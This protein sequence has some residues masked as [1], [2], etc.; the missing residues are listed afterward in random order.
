MS[1]EIRLLGRPA[2]L[3]AGGEIQP[4]R[5]LQAW[6]LLARII[7]ARTAPDRRELAQELFPDAADPLGA[8]RW[9]LASLRRALKSAE[10]LSGDPIVANLPAGTRVDIHALEKGTIDIDAA[11]DL[12]D[13][14]EPRSS[15]SFATWLL[16]ERERI[17]ALINEKLRQEAMQAVSVGDHARAIHLAERGVRRAPLDEGA[18]ILLVKSLAL[19]G[20]DAAAQEH[21]DATEKAF[22]AELGEKPTAALRSAARRTVFSDAGG[23][24][25]RAVVTSLID[26]GAAALAAGAVDAGLDSLRRAVAEAERAQDRA[27]QAKALLELGTALVHSVRGF[28]DEGA[29]LLRQSVQLAQECGAAEIAIGALR[30]AGYVEA[31]AGRR[32]SAAAFLESALK[33]GGDDDGRAGIHSVIGFNLVDWGRTADG[34][35]HLERSVEFARRAQNRRRAA[36]ALSMG[37]MG[38]LAAGNL[39]AAHRWLTECRAIVEDLRWVAFRPWPMASLCE[40]ELQRGT[41][42]AELRPELESAFALS[43]QLRDPCWEGAVARVMALTYA[44]TND[45][46]RAMS[47]LSEARERCLRETDVYAA[48]LVGIVAAQAEISLQSGQRESA[49]AIARELLSLAAKAHMDA[50]V[51]RAVVLIGRKLAQ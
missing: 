45:C 33:L 9:C 42:P 7:M 11:G 49:Q 14:V 50:H 30:E 27:L 6:A 16:V 24:S 37:G 34:L 25:T 39:D 5:G 44:A 22:L 13:G 10:A 38:H 36:W 47:W 1:V 32:P 4:V 35:D 51:D 17:A 41:A 19:G 2:I 21:V 12:L 31:L 20:R 43:C 15:P 48:L 18:H 23:V 26:A 40:V 3:D 8:L 29:L 28:D 46:P